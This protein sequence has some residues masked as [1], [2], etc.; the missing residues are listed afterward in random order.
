MMASLLAAVQDC[1]REWWVLSELT[2]GSWLWVGAVL[3]LGVRG[4]RI[5]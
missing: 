5:R 3:A 4:C 1:A 2:L